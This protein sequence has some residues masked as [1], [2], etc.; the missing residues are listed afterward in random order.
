[1]IV[2]A[3]P[4]PEPTPT[5]PPALTCLAKHYAVTPKLD[6]AAWFAV[7]PDG[8]RIAWDDGRTKTDEETLDDPDVE[9]VFAEP[10]STGPIVPNH[11]MENGPGRVRLEKVFRATY[12]DD[13]KAVEAKLVTITF[14]GK[15]LRVHEKA[16]DVFV[17][18]G[19]RVAAVIAADPSAKKFLEDM[20]GTFVWRK[21]A[22]TN[23]ASSHSFGVSLDF[24]PSLGDYWRWAKGEPKW[25][26]RVPAALV[27]A[28]EAE[29]FVWGGR[30]GKY[31]TMHFEWRPE[32]FCA[33][34]KTT[35]STRS[36]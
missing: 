17:A 7:L 29:G 33:Q 36:P 1:M 35:E 13:A 15:K 9:D 24:N 22:G 34:E 11:D 19:T 4:P 3:A 2:L 5:P 26:N 31:D 30:W 25:T 27:D 21:V 23:R 16:K 28:M 14:A 8:S 18:A 6:G 32:L 10:Y 12:G 20:G